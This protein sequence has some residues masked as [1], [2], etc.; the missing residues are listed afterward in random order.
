MIHNLTDQSSILSVFIS[1]I[2][3]KNIQ[4]D[5]MRF[6]SNLERIGEVLGYELSKNLTYE[7]QEVITTLGIANCDNLVQQPVLATILRAGVPLHNGLL[8]FFDRAENAFVSA[9][10]KPHKNGEFEVHVEYLSSPN[11]EGKTLIIADPMLATGASMFLV[12]KALLNKGVPQKIHIVS[13]IASQ[14]ALDSLQKKLPKSTEFWVGAIDEELTALSYIVPG[15]G[16]AGDL[17]YGP[18]Y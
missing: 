8:S 15:L 6:R 14:E 3:D 11:L 4:S 10:R 13:A 7:R 18:K 9:Y 17:A 2:R 16:D 12:Y 1:E 5:S